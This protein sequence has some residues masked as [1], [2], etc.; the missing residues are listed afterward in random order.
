MLAT[1][2]T[3]TALKDVAE[4]GVSEINASVLNEESE[5]NDLEA[6]YYPIAQRDPNDVRTILSLAVSS[7]VFAA[8]GLVLSGLLTY[9]LT[10][11]PSL[12]VVERTA[13]GDRVVGDDRQYTFGGPVQ[14]R[15]DRPGDGDKKYVAA[16]WAETFIQGVAFIGIS[17]QER[18]GRSTSVTNTQKPDNNNSRK[19]FSGETV[20]Q[21][22]APSTRVVIPPVT[23]LHNPEYISGEASINVAANSDLVTVEKSPSLKRDHHLILRAGSGFLVPSAR[24]KGVQA[25]APAT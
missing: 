14:V 18:S 17:A 10:R 2:T 6:I 22:G 23:I 5:T 12:I 8:L 7:L 19:R 11:S 3:I 24:A 13:E 1:T 20:R 9:K 15:A 4:P 25:V 16:K 21:R